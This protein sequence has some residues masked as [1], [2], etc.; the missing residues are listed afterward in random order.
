MWLAAIVVVTVWLLYSPVSSAEFY[1]RR[2]HLGRTHLS[3]LPPRSFDHNGEIR[4][5]Y[6]PNSIVYQH[7]K[8]LEALADQ[9]A[10]IAQAQEQEARE[11]ENKAAVLGALKAP[12][13]R[14]LPREGN[15]NLDE[16]IALEKRGGRWQPGIEE[17][18]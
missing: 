7:A 4:R 18:P 17:R 5:A 2:D 3:N 6:D 16:L 10:E 8:M 12:P 11:I 15:M 13:A 1:A 9:S 14:G